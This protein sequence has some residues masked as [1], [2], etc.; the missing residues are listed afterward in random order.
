V[1]M[2]RQSGR[3]SGDWPLHGCSSKLAQTR[4]AAVRRPGRKGRGKSSGS[5]TNAEGGTK[6]G[7]PVLRTSDAAVEQSTPSKYCQVRLLGAGD[8]GDR[9]GLV[10]CG[11]TTAA[12]NDQGEEVKVSQLL[13]AVDPGGVE[14]RA[15][16]K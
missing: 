6:V 15:I 14:K 3:R 11:E 13:M 16:E 2:P 8:G 12:R 1:K 9:N 7:V 5:E 4:R 10:E